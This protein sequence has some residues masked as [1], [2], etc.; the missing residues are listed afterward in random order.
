MAQLNIEY[1][2]SICKTLLKVLCSL[3][4]VVVVSKQKNETLKY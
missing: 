1:L 4:T 3:Q 2:N